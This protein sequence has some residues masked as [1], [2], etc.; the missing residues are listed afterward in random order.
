MTLFYAEICPGE[1]ELRWVRAGH[2]PAFLY[3]PYQDKFEEL[4]GEGVALGVDPNGKY[5]ENIIDGLSN[6][7]ILVIGTDGVWEAQNI[8]GEMFG[9]QQLKRIIQKNANLAA[10]VILTTIIDSLKVFQ[11]SVKQQD[12][13]TL[14]IIKAA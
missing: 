7:Q 3:D 12:D 8:K 14:V 4:Q 10:E 1:K 9:K 11:K 5:Q 13:V 6:G 2:D